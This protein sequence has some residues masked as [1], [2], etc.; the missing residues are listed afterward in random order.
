M[1]RIPAQEKMKVFVLD[2][3]CELPSGEEDV[4]SIGVYS[5]EESAQEAITRLS[6]KPKLDISK[7]FKS[8][9]VS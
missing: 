2:R 9:A 3:V 4:K 6:I 8:V 5:S 7:V 1:G